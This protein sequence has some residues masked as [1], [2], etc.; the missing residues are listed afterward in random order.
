[1]LFLLPSIALTASSPFREEPEGHTTGRD[2][3]ASN[4]PQLK[5]E[6]WLETF[7]GDFNSF[8]GMMTCFK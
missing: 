3:K 6:D 7:L 4:E 5:G 8:E 2:Q 1:M